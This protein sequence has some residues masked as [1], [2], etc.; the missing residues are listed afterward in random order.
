MILV[1]SSASVDFIRGWILLHIGARVNISLISDYLIKLMRLPIA[2]FDTKMTGDIL[3]RINDHSR[4]ENFLTNSSLNTLFSIFNIAI[5]GAVILIYDWRIFLIFF[6]GSFI[7]VLW[8]WLFMKKRAILDNK[9]FTQNSANQSNIIQLVTSMQ[10]IKLNACEQQKRWEWEHIQAKLYKLN[11]KGLVLAQYQESGGILINQ[12]KNIL[13]TALVASFV[14]KGQITLGMMLAIQ[15]IIG[16]LNSP[17]EQLIVFFRQLQDANLSIERLQDIYEKDDEVFDMQLQLQ[18]IPDNA[19][20]NIANLFFSYDKLA[21]IP[22]L[23]NINL[24]IPVS[25]THLRAHET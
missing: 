24:C 21:P 6:I 8:V 3:Q 25:Y 2:Y 20:I 7:Y 18:D 15:Y 16:Q 23:K 14:I 4:I 5:L 1:L 10:E 19:S 22:T 13:I 17:I 9:S 11:I 12:I